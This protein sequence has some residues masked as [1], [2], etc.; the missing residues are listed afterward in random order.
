MS[1]TPY[2]SVSAFIAHCRALHDVGGDT[3]A[4]PTPSESA[5]LDEIERLLSELSKDE[6][7]ALGFARLGESGG[8]PDPMASEGSSATAGQPSDAVSRR[9]SRAELKLHRVLTAHGL[10][11][12]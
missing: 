1:L 10:L 9:R 3:A 7:D 12:S 2:S 8:R 11:A 5:A 6:R 4:S